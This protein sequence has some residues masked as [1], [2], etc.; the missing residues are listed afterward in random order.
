MATRK[1]IMVVDKK[2]GEKKRLLRPREKFEK[3]KLE[4]KTGKH[5]TNMGKQKKNK[6]GKVKFLTKEQKAYRAGY[7]QSVI[8]NTKFSKAV[9]KLKGKK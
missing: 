2:T 4:L 3:V 6:N 7:R 9:K 5:F 8:D 1:P